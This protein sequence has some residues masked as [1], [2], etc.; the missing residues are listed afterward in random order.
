MH[1]QITPTAAKNLVNRI[2]QSEQK[3]PLFDKQYQHGVVSVGL[4]AE[5][6]QRILAGEKP[7]NKRR[8]SRATIDEE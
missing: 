5:I 3:R 2:F 6:Q 1:L 4:Q 7:E 8:R